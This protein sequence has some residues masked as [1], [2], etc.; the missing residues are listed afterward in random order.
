MTGRRSPSPGCRRRTGDVISVET[1][2]AVP[3]RPWS[4]APGTYMPTSRLL[5]EAL[6]EITPADWSRNAWRGMPTLFPEHFLYVYGTLQ[7]QHDAATGITTI[8]DSA[9]TT[10]ASSDGALL[11]HQTS[12]IETPGVLRKITHPF[13]IARHCH[14]QHRNMT[15]GHDRAEPNRTL[16]TRLDRKCKN[17]V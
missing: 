3:M 14:L 17:I 9:A 12:S 6:L 16:P 1:P 2:E 11:T 15:L 7:K 10:G 5:C 8:P 4:H 13:Q